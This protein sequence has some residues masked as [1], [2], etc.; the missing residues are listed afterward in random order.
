MTVWLKIPSQGGGRARR[1]SALIAPS[2][3][4]RSRRASRRRRTPGARARRALAVDLVAAAVLAA[5]ALG[6]AAGL[7][8]I[9]FLGLPILLV[10]LVWIGVERAAGRLRRRRLRRS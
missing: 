2:P 4:R 5:V 9:A 3:R 1:D 6:L 8:V 7:G 10:G